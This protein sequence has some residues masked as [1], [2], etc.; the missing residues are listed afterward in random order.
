LL[1]FPYSEKTSNIPR[2]RAISTC[3]FLDSSFMRRRSS[4]ATHSV[5]GSFYS[6][7]DSTGP[8][9]QCLEVLGGLDYEILG[10]FEV[11]GREFLPGEAGVVHTALVGFN[12]K[13]GSHRLD[14]GQ[15]VLE[16]VEVEGY[17][18]G[19]LFLGFFIFS[20]LTIYM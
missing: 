10:F 20:P 18:L 17:C 14:L 15:Q 7:A 19:D 16:L 6:C 12:G 4:P 5:L 8:F 11:S 3:F 13:T 2:N 9:A 1:E